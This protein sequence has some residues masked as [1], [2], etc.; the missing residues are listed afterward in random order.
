MPSRPVSHGLPGTGPS[1]PPAWS[2]CSAASPV[3][4]GTPIT[5]TVRIAAGRQGE[6]ARHDGEPPGV[7]PPVRR[8]L[9]DRRAHRPPPTGPWAGDQTPWRHRPHGRPTIST[10]VRWLHKGILVTNPLRLLCD[11][12][13]VAPGVVDGMLTEF[14]VR[15]LV[16]LPAA[17]AALARHAA[18]GRNGISALRAAIDD[19]ELS[20]KPPDSVLEEGMARL[21][22][23]FDPPS[24]AI[25]RGDR[26][27]RGRLPHPRHAGDPGV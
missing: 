1:T 19:Q 16:S 26:G 27:L 5:T 17:K 15:G 9:P 22:K 12:G 10:S 3:L 24:D 6:R 18:K 4:P 8:L 7:C 25:P 13:A 21:R 11:I 2:R 23:R 14:R 20:D